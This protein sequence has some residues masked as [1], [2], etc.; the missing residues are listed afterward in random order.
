MMTNNEAAKWIQ[1]YIDLAKI[2]PTTGEEAYLN[3]DAKKTLEAMCMA[4]DALIDRVAAED[5]IIENSKEMNGLI[6]RSDALGCFHDW[7]DKYGDVH[8][9]D[10]MAEYRA[11]EE[12]PSA[13][14]EVVRCKDCKHIQKWR[15]EESAKKFGQI[16]ECAGGVLNCPKPEDFCSHAER[17]TDEEFKPRR[18]NRNLERYEY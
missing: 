13:Q 9:P 11:I 14:P 15:S 1:L 18:S 6:R 16:Y 8:T 3:E 2:D 17:R 5:R 7:V 4:V 12:L 10:E